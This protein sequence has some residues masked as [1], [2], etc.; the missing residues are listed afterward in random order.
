MKKI[1]FSAVCVS[2]IAALAAVNDY[3]ASAT[4]VGTAAQTNSVTI[5]GVVEGV[6][7][8]VAANAT[9]AVT[10]TTAQGQTI[11]NKT[12]ITADTY[13]PVRAPVFL[14]TGVQAKFT[15]PTSSTN[16]VLDKIAV[17]GVVT[18]VQTSPGASGTNTISTTILYSR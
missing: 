15:D 12:G 10:I 3:R 18:V 5:R 11:L 13:F 17:G 1:L 8:D 7:V 14:T 6:Y 16:D 9:G 2:A 4:L